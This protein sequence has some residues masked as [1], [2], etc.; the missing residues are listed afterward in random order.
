MYACRRLFLDVNSI[1]WLMAHQYGA[2]VRP[3]IIEPAL[4][5]CVRH[6]PK[7]QRIKLIPSTGRSNHATRWLLPRTVNDCFT[8]RE[9]V[10]ERIRVA[11]CTG[12]YQGQRRYFITGLGGTG[13]SEVCLKFAYNAIAR[14][15]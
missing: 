13:K 9:D 2:E 11:L 12:D 5:S 3:S 4:L 7:G 10:M 14:Q 1:L 6:S 15:E 8:G